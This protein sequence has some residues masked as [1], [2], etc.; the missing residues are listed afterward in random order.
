[1]GNAPLWAEGDERDH[2]RDA[3][4]AEVYDNSEEPIVKMNEAKA[5]GNRAFQ[6]G[7]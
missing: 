4:E 6:K 5:R 7:E 2:V 3:L 1:M